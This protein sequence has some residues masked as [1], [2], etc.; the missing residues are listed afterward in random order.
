VLHFLARSREY[1]PG[2]LPLPL[3]NALLATEPGQ[4]RVGHFNA[5][6]FQ[7]FLNPNQIS[8]AVTVQ[9]A[10]LFQMARPVRAG[11]SGFTVPLLSTFMTVFTLIFNTDAII[12]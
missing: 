1:R 4:R 12:R 2:R 7:L 3:A 10:Y 11:G 5:A 8:T 9:F 6:L